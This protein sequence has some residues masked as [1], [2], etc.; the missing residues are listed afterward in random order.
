MLTRSDILIPTAAFFV[1]V[2]L[3]VTRRTRRNLPYPPGPKRWPIIGNLLDLP[4]RDEW[5]TYKKWSD[6]YGSDIVHV[7]AAGTHIVV[8]NSE[9]AANELFDKR[10]S[11]YSD[12]P[13]LVALN[14]ILKLDWVL[15]FNP[16]GAKWRALRRAFHGHF[17]PTASRAYH[18]LELHATRRLLRN[19]LTTP[20]D[21]AQHLRHMAGQVILAIAY[22]IDVQPHSDPYVATAEKS[23]HAVALASSMGGGLFD[24]IPWLINMPDWFPGAAFKREARR[25]LPHVTGMLE[26]PYAAVQAGLADGTAAPSVA[27]SMTTHLSEDSTAEEVMLA[28]FLPGNIYLGG[29]DT[30]VSALQT[31]F[32][33][34][35]LNPEAQR[36]A[37]AEIDAVVGSTR[38]PDF[39]DEPALPYVGAVLKEVLRWHPV[40]PLAIPHRLTQDD[41][42]EGY[43][44]PAGSIV[45]GNAWAM[46]HDPVAFPEPSRF[47]PERWLAPDAPPFPEPAFGFGRR[48]CPGR[49][50]ARASVWAAISAVLSSFNIEP[51]AD[52]PPREIYA[53]GI[54]SCVLS[55]RRPCLDSNGGMGRY[56]ESFRCKITPRSETAAALVRATAN[57]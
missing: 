24:V 36:K 5:I 22:G 38:L 17:H 4:S 21:F 55:S 45:I 1:T 57:E 19:L 47:R 10:S 11:V 16:Y 39:S 33:A 35:A 15:G 30:T 18:S 43:L 20:D 34:M 3:Y 2:L 28:K 23:L 40:V 25:W 54:V 41:I 44:I 49:F 12:R 9:K 7:D 56:P 50:M 52:D 13:P 8:V 51:Y 29:A 32:L 48:E 37:Q 14:R 42:Y 46:M 53:S 31:F 27:A 6:E 26:D